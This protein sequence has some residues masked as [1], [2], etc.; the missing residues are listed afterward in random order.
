MLQTDKRAILA[1]SCTVRGLIAMTGAGNTGL[2]AR[3]T[4]FID[5]QRA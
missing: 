4:F 3:V 1:A 5:G 2:A